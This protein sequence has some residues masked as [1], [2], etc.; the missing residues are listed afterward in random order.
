M[1]LLLNNLVK[2]PGVSEGESEVTGDKIHVYKALV[3]YHFH[4]LPDSSISYKYVLTSENTNAIRSP[5]CICSKLRTSLLLPI[6]KL[7]AEPNLLVSGAKNHH[8]S[9]E[10]HQ[11]S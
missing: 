3:G 7:R 6:Q 5:L 1:I 11:A 9:L 4:L 10:S 8:R 2:M